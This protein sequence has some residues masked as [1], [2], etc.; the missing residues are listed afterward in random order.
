M[1]E[2]T[3]QPLI[4]VMGHPLLDMQVTDGEPLLKKYGL[5]PNDGIQAEDRHMSMYACIFF[6]FGLL[7]VRILNMAVRYDEIAR[8]WKVTYAAGGTANAA[9][10][11]AVRLL[12][13]LFCRPA[14]LTVSYSTSSRRVLWYTLDARAMMH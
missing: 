13:A 2:P 3:V 11:A 7:P 12:C 10:A 9:R 8:D 5:Q 1:S 14:G 6:P 4:F